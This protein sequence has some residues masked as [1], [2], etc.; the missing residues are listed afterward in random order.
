M[1]IR[2]L[3]LRLLPLIGLW[4][5]AG[6]ATAAEVASSRGGGGSTGGVTRGQLRFSDAERLFRG[7]IPTLA[8]LDAHYAQRAAAQCR[9]SWRNLRGRAVNEIPVRANYET[10]RAQ[11]RLKGLSEKKLNRALA[12]FL[13]N[14][15]S[16][17][18]QNFVTVIDF[19]KPSAQKRL[20]TI[21][22]KTGAVDAF[23]VAA[24]YGS[25]PTGNGYATKFS[26]QMDES[27]ASS[28]GC[29]VTNEVF[30]GKK[31]R[32]SLRFHGIESTND[33]ACQRGIYMHPADEYVG[34]ARGRSEGCPA[35]R[36]TDMK[37]LYSRIGHG[38]LVC[39]DREGAWTTAPG[40]Y[41]RQRRHH[42]SRTHHAR[43]HHRYHRRVRS[44]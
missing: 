34:S 31:Q 3:T 23:S 22:L 19:D 18:N 13:K 32:P 7:Q 36:S 41:R 16:L 37:T 11:A 21:D 28:L 42:G 9:G 24:G 40:H 6:A 12:V 27:N 38:G 17:P 43:R 29:Y 14:Q 1:D 33:N 20:F 8:H 2:T 25:D 26:N 5:I 35:I 30:S 15:K 4:L 10:M 39:A 44:Y